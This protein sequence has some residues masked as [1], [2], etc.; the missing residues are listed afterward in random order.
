MM[1]FLIVT[2]L[3]GAGKT[4]AVHALEDI[5]FYCVD[6]LP[7]QLLET[8]YSLCQQAGEKFGRVA[9]VT[10]IRGGQ[11]VFL[12]LAG[13]L[14][15]MRREGKP[16]KILFLNASDSVLI[17][18]FKET[19]R[20]HPLADFFLGSLD[21]AVQMERSVLQ[22]VREMAD[23]VIDTSLLAPAQ[24]K[25]QLASLFL[26]SAQD[27]LS[28]HCLSFGF[29]YGLPPEADLVFDVRC[30]PNPYYMPEL[31][32]LTGLDD[33]VRDYVMRWEQSQEVKKRLF[34]LID[35]MLPLYVEEGK[36]Q[37]VVAVGCTGGK[38]R[39]VTF[40]QLLYEHFS[41][42]GRKVSVSHRDIQKR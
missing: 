29:K 25:K 8:F 40:A 37:L 17:N 34:S 16:Y 2:G 26:G 18:R 24:L 3:S 9:V 4:Q 21:K 20:K 30:L 31:K 41:A 36:S 39:S 33:P 1:E 42:E 5:G 22:P 13:T 38:H 27:A 28:I 7:P 11:D 23:Y 35:Y 10:D 6:N 32:P 15:E 14:E 12:T 19:R